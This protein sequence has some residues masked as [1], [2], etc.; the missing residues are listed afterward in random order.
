MPVICTRPLLRRTAG[1]VMRSPAARWEAT[2]FESGK[3]LD[4]RCGTAARLLRDAA[5]R[6]RG[7][8]PAAFRPRAAS[9]GRFAALRDASALERA[10][11]AL[12]RA[13]PHPSWTAHAVATLPLP[14]ARRFLD[15]LGPARARVV[16]A[17][18]DAELAARLRTAAPAPASD[19]A[20][21]LLA[22]RAP[23]AFPPSPPWAVPL[24]APDTVARA[25]ARDPEWP[26]ARERWG[27]AEDAAAAVARH[28]ASTESR[29]RATDAWPDA[30]IARGLARLA[31]ALFGRPDEAWGLAG[32]WPRR[33]GLALLAAWDAWPDLGALDPG[34]VP[35]RERAADRLRERWSSW[36]G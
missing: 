2:V 12:P 24:G 14:V 15:R 11:A 5:V 26:A 17:E 16:L 34:A 22:R 23:A 27:A 25:A 19:L 4:I 28:A 6:D 35:A 33:G 9:D 18:L 10:D 31:F 7:G 3:R 20:E 8:G 36:A 21:A 13:V 30:E 29:A 1:G 32:A